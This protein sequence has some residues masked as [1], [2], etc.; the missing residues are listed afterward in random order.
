M[1]DP[2]EL[3]IEREMS[4]VDE[5]GTY[6]CV[7]CGKRTPLETMGP[8]DETPD[9]PLICEGCEPIFEDELEIF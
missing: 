6:P 8:L 2:I 7:V 5:A 9:S 1:V 3:R 4:K